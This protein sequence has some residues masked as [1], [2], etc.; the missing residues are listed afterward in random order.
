MSTAFELLSEFRKA[1]DKNLHDFYGKAASA[2]D[3]AM[4]TSDDHHLVAF[5]GG[6]EFTTR[7]CEVSERA[8]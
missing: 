6:R 4:P 3:T 2:A 7:R 5:G 1:L 8:I